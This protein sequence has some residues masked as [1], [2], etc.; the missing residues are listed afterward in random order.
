ML[1]DVSSTRSVAPRY[2]SMLMPAGR[3]PARSRPCPRSASP[4]LHDRQG[5]EA[6][7]SGRR[8]APLRSPATAGGP[9]RTSRGRS[10]L[11]PVRQPREAR[12]HHQDARHLGRRRAPASLTTAL[13]WC[14]CANRGA[15][16]PS[17]MRRIFGP[18]LAGVAVAHAAVAGCASTPDLRFADADSATDASTPLPDSGGGGGD[19]APD[20]GAVDTGAVDSG[21]AVDAASTACPS[22]PPPSG[23]NACCDTY[24]CVDRTSNNSCAT[25]AACLALRCQTGEVCCYSKQGNGNLSCRTSLANCK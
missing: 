13:L 21:A 14:A 24:P 8:R 9:T 10:G 7:G 12:R 3:F 20:T 22:S 2:A 25:C 16:I 17:S 5:G 6:L 19:A 4:G 15:M 11:R 18:A 1:N 23:A